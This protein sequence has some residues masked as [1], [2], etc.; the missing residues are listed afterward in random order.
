MKITG[1]AKMR[2]VAKSLDL[3]ARPFR[4]FL[5]LEDLAEYEGTKISNTPPP[6]WKTLL[7]CAALTLQA[8]VASAALIFN[9]MHHRKI[10]TIS[11]G[12]VTLSWVCASLSLASPY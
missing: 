9:L 8:A 1:I 10:F 3:A 6:H 5:Q 2:V 4:N 7:L 12:L 11:F